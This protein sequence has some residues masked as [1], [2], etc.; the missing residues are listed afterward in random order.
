MPNEDDGIN[1]FTDLGKHLYVHHG[2]QLGDFQN[3]PT[4]EDRRV[5]HDLAMNPMLG[6]VQAGG[7][8]GFEAHAMKKMGYQIARIPVLG[9]VTPS[10]VSGH[11]E[12]MHGG[13]LTMEEHHEAHQNGVAN[14][15]H[16]IL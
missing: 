8:T 16:I 7:T 14:H 9:R 10:W 12:A 5:A 2:W 4:E 15:S 1:Y 11:G 13:P 6:S 3:H